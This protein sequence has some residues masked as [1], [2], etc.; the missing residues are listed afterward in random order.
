MSTIAEDEGS[1]PDTSEQRVTDII[2]GA[3]VRGE[4]APNQRL[5]EAD[6]SDTFGASRATVRTALLEL[7]NEGLVERLPNR[8]SRVRA[9]SVDEAI[10]ILEVRIG[11]EGLCSAK[12]A[13]SVTDD[14][15]QE[16]LRLREDLIAAVADG[17]LVEYSRL[18]Q[19]LD[20]R[21]RVLSRHAT[22]AEVL[23]RLHAQSV[24][25]QF[26]LSSRPQRAKVSVLEHAAIIDAIVARDPGA[27]EQAVRAHLLSV[28]GALREIA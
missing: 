8:G 13:A 10:E 7:A 25:H 21:V 17:D 3:I 26:K 20:E 19:R 23:A 24:R 2:R 16:F 9:I 22:A 15:I 28:I 5:I 14:E 11:V 12:T 4:Y 18:N 6:L 27:A 1:A